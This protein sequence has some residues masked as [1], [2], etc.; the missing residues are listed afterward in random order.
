MKQCWL[1]RAGVSI[2]PRDDD[3]EVEVFTAM[4]ALKEGRGDFADRRTLL[5][6]IKV[7]VGPGTSTTIRQ[8]TN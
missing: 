4:T 5:A 1:A 3:H 6:R 7:T 8:A 2:E